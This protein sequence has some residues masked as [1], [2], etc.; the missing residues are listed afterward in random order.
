[1]FLREIWVDCVRNVCTQN[2]LFLYKNALDMTMKHLFP[3]FQTQYKQYIL[4]FSSA[5]RVAE[6][7][8]LLNTEIFQSKDVAP[9]KKSNT[10]QNQYFYEINKFVYEQ[11]TRKTLSFIYLAQVIHCQLY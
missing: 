2:S 7:W 4:N 6:Q 8:K 9:G 10:E 1:M 5:S 11:P 3:T